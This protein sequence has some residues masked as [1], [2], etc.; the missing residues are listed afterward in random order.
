MGRGSKRKKEDTGA[1]VE[2]RK[3]TRERKKKSFGE[4]FEELYS[5]PKGISNPQP[6][7]S[8]DPDPE[9]EPP[10]DSVTWPSEPKYWSQTL[11]PNHHKHYHFIRNSSYLNHQHF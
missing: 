4:D 2:P 1:K 11:P 3:S 5:P 10:K 7:T 9:P 8:T 6:G